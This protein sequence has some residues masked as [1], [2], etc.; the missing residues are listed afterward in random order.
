[1][2]LFFRKLHAVHKGHII[3]HLNLAVNTDKLR[4]S[5]SVGS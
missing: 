3:Y 1:M 5:K 4:E 2:V